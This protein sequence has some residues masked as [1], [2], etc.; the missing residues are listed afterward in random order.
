MSRI[1]CRLLVVSCFLSF[2]ATL[3]DFFS[4]SFL[5]VFTSLFFLADALVIN[6]QNFLL[7]PQQKGMNGFAPRWLVAG[8][9]SLIFHPCFYCRPPCSDATSKKKTTL[10]GPESVSES[11]I[12]A[13]LSLDENHAHTDAGSLPGGSVEAL[14]GHRRSRPPGRRPLC[15]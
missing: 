4:N 3:T 12:E 11:N 8:R 7:K 6:Q 14:R 1:S 2:H 5:S 13:V 9:E 15:D 10:T